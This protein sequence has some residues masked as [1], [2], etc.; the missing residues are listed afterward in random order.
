V[1]RETL[2]L[3]GTEVYSISGV[4][5]LIPGGRVLVTAQNEA[6]NQTRF[7]AIVRLNSPVEVEY[8]RYGGILPRVLRLFLGASGS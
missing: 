8:L 2:G 4:S 3:T 6:G 7:P 5:T 1:N